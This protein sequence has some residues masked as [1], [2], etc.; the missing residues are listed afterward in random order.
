MLLIGKQRMWMTLDTNTDTNTVRVARRQWGS[1][2][3]STATTLLRCIFQTLPTCLLSNSH[4][5]QLLATWHRTSTTD[6]QTS[7]ARLKKSRD[8]EVYWLSLAHAS[9]AVIAMIARKCIRKCSLPNYSYIAN[10][11]KCSELSWLN[12]CDNQPVDADYSITVTS[13]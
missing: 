6:R 12:A 8:S 1:S 3:S 5:A 11:L 13:W 7:V 4:L 10:G 2:R 9:D